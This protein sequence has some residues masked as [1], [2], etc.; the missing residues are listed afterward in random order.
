MTKDYSKMTKEELADERERL[1]QILSPRYASNWVEK[2]LFEKN[3]FKITTFL[4]REEVNILVN[5]YATLEGFWG[6]EDYYTH[7][8]RIKKVDT[9]RFFNALK[10]E[11]KSNDLLDCM[12]EKFSAD[13]ADLD[14]ISFC[15]RNNIQFYYWNNIDGLVN[16]S[17]KKAMNKKI[18]ALE[19]QLH[20]VRNNDYKI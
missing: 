3:D 4:L 15:K 8:I 2:T 10:N 18:S 6:D 13:S 14:L 20:Q 5:T 12:V 19:K 9:D 7:Y 16:S 1:A 11:C 17:D